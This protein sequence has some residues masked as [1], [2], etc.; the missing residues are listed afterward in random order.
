MKVFRVHFSSE[1]SNGDLFLEAANSDQAAQQ[2]KKLIH[3]KHP[4]VKIDWPQYMALPCFI[5][6]GPPTILKP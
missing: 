6:P 2:A 3:E 1:S 5:P 4:G